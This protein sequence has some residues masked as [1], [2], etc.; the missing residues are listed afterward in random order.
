[1]SARRVVSILVFVASAS[2]FIRVIF[3]LNGPPWRKLIIQFNKHLLN[4]LALRMASRR[5]MYYAILHHVGRRSGASYST[6][7]VVKLTPE[8]A[9]IPLP[10]GA[11]TDWCRNVLDAGGCSVTLNGREMAFTAPTLTSAGVVEPLVPAAT[12]RVWRHAGIKRYLRLASTSPA[13]AEPDHSVT[14]EPR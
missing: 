14:C 1:M 12:A 6:P 9:V 7:V 4:P 2:V 10:Y 8:G 13:T 3:G 5:P 11:G